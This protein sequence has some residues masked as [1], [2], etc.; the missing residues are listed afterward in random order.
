[1]TWEGVPWMVDQAEH[2]AEVGRLLAYMSTGNGEGVIGASDCQ[3]H[4]SAIPDGNVHIT[5]GGIAM[6]NRFSGGSS[7]AYISRNVG[8]EVKALTPQGSSG[9]R[10]DL[11]CVIVEDPEYPG[12]P[13]PVSVPNG[14]YVRTAVYENVPSTTTALSQVDADQTGYALALVKFDASDGTVNTADITDLRQLLIQRTKTEKRAVNSTAGNVNLPGALA[15]APPEASWSIPVPIWANQVILEA[16][17]SGVQM[18]DTG[19]GAGSA[20]GTAR[21]DLGTVITQVT[22][23]SE[24][25]TAVNKPVTATIAVADTKTIPDVMK[26]TTQNLI[27]KLAK[28]AGTGMTARTTSWTTVIVTATFLEVPVA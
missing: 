25:A 8:D 22:G 2:S 3:V 10:W 17:W 26:G 9:P 13:A 24:D 14:P 16:V 15:V 5:P 4:A 1:M 20:S 19:T 21:V 27:A 28:T 18:L 6:L 7:Q 11:V 12:Q 23:W